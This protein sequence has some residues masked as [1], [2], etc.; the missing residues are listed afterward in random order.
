MLGAIQS[1][2]G[3]NGDLNL[4]RAAKNIFNA[5]VESVSAA[6]SLNAA[7]E[8]SIS[9]SCRVVGAGKAAMAMAAALEQKFPEYTF[10]G[11]VVVPHGYIDSFPQGRIPPRTIEVMEGGHPVPDMD[12]Q[13]AALN[14]IEIAKTCNEGDTLVVLLSGGASALWSLPSDDLTLDD[15]RVVNQLLLQ[16][17]ANIHAINIL[18]KHLSAIKGGQ[19]SRA[20]WPAHIIT[21]AI[22]DVIGDFPSVI[23]SG[24]TVADPTTWQDA[25][26][27]IQ[28]FD[29]EVP[30]IVLEHIKY[31]IQ[32]IRPDTP[33]P[34]SDLLKRSH[35][36]LLATN[37]DALN[38][39]ES[40]ASE[41][42]YDVVEID[43]S[44][45]GEARDIG[46]IMVRQI[47]KLKP[48]QCLLWGGET[49]VT[50][51]GDGKGGRN[52]E[53]IL[54][55]A[56]Q[57]D[58]AAV[59]S[60]ILSGGTDGIDGP[61]DA[62]GGWAIPATAQAIRSRSIDPHVALETN[63]SYHCLNAVN[64]LLVTGPTHTNVMDIGI[65]LTAHE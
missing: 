53:L 5:A 16:S 24:P 28:N 1:G 40:A 31:G 61:T 26:A 18:R 60:V 38:A 3:R 44:V 6:Q 29:M 34:D 50:I 48:G 32:G 59:D 45:N 39:A 9:G 27:V 15:L 33:K 22:S 58:G 56:C 14:A 30:D 12:S 20:A 51:Q 17:G 49:T 7:S 57:L 19:L 54:A 42:G 11:Q 64:Q 35:F 4:V 8:L 37:A 55:A 10:E 21:L 23:G 46:E 36:Q 65:G 25:M 13:Q 63:D 41:L 62:A 43:Y 52:Q 47:E 2:E